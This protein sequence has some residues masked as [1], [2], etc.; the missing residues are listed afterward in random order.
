[1]QGG[2]QPGKPEKFREFRQSSGKA[3]IVSRVPSDLRFAVT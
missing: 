1:M 2:P 3:G